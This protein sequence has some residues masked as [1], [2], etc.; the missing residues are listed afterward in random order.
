MESRSILFMSFMFAVL[1]AC[2]PTEPSHSPEPSSPATSMKT[3]EG[4][5][6]TSG[7]PVPN[8]DEFCINLDKDSVTVGEEIS[9][10]ISWRGAPSDSVMHVSLSRSD[11]DRRKIQNGRIKEFKRIGKLN[12]RF[13]GSLLTNPIPI[14]GDGSIRFTWSGNGFGCYRGELPE[15]CPGEAAPGWHVITV[16]VLDK[17][18]IVHPFAHPDARRNANPELIFK[19][20]SQVFKIR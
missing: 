17:S 7:P 11:G 2:S 3:T 20:R 14:E 12:E 18:T 8:C 5:T 1:P 10:M 6:L 4:L 19:G 15:I 16:T 9:G 13:D